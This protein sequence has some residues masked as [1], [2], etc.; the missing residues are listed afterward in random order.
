MLQKVD[1]GMCQRGFQSQIIIIE[2]S[3]DNL[4][5]SLFSHGN[6]RWRQIH[7]CRGLLR[8][9]K[10]PNSSF[11]HQKKIALGSATHYEGSTRSGNHRLQ[12]RGNLFADIFQLSCID[13]I[14][15]SANEMS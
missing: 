9:E 5:F 6:S 2:F 11:F 1:Y 14:S 7:V 10:P 3:A 8:A 15:D 13:D 12:F 4:R